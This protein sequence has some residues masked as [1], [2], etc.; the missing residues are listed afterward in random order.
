VEMMAI[1]QRRNLRGAGKGFAC[2]YTSV[3][4]SVDVLEYVYLSVQVHVD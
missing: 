3:V 2:V 4:V 1:L